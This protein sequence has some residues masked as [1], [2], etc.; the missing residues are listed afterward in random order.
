MNKDNMLEKV[1]NEMLK[2]TSYCC[3]KE[4]AIDLIQLHLGK[5]GR[6]EAAEMVVIAQ[7]KIPLKLSSC[8]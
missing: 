1:K 6:L 8:T 5:V 2:T 7:K 3:F 4:L